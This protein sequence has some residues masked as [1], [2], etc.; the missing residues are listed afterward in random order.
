MALLFADGF[1]HYG[2]GQAAGNRMVNDGAY[3]VGNNS[4]NPRNSI[5]PRTGPYCLVSGSSTTNVH[6]TR[7]IGG[8]YNVVGVAVAMYY[9][10]LIG[11]CGV[12]LRGNL[13]GYDLSV[14]VGTTGT[15]QIIKNTTNAINTATVIAET[16][17]GLI[18]AGAW[19]HIEFKAIIDPVVGGFELRV[20]G[21]TQLVVN[22][23]NTGSTPL[24][25]ITLVTSGNTVA[26][27]D[28]I[29][30]NDQGDAPR[31]FVGPARVIT[32][33][34]ASDT[35]VA[36]FAKVGAA[37]GYE[38]INQT[39]QDGDTTYIEGANVGDASEFGLGTLPPET[40]GIVGVYVPTL[41][42]LSEAGTGDLRVSI[43]SGSDTK[44]GFNGPLTQAYA[45]R[46]SAFGIN[47]AT[48]DPWSKSALEAARLRFE[49]TA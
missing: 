7:L 5:P 21:E 28:L 9:S 39:V 23:V 42:K 16:P 12:L 2:T 27:D 4:V 20:N 18:T 32:T 36:D 3:A 15:V 10:N 45:Y 30:W 37:T 11:S 41:A 6:T 31:D 17:P 19:N 22:N 34:P 43:V 14:R 46:D 35:P 38:C 8:P 26:F 49:R 33:Y 44:Q 25:R 29:I 24:S 1:D 48:G 13:V 40:E 47:P